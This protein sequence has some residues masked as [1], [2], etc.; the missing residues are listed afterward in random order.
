MENIIKNFFNNH[1]LKQEDLYSI[2]EAWGNAFSPNYKKE[3]IDIILGSNLCE[4]VDWS[5]V[6]R[7][8]AQNLHMSVVYIYNSQGKI[9]KTYVD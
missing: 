8:L 6:L 5:K 9:I 3:Y 7:D 2:L 4:F 1:T